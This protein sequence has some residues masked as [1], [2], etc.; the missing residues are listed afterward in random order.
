VS[1]Y[2]EARKDDMMNEYDAVKNPKHYASGKI[3][4]IEAI[5]DWK[6]DFCLGNAVK[7]IARAGKKDPNKEIEDLEK[8]KWYIER[9]ISELKTERYTVK[10]TDVDKIDWNTIRVRPM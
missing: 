4:P 7:Y 2:E 5:E 9:R 1:N 6:L 8:A 3:Q 10:L